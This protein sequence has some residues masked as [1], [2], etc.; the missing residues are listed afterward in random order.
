MNTITQGQPGQVERISPPNDDVRAT[1]D[2]MEKIAR[3]TPLVILAVLVGL[4]VVSSLLTGSS[5][6]W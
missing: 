5:M 6:H 1:V 2:Q 4:P 3:L